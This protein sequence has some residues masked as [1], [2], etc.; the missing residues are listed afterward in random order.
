MNGETGKMGTT[1]HSS[2]GAAALSVIIPV[3]NAPAELDRCLQSVYVS[4]PPGTEVILIDDASPD[5]ATR[6]VLDR[7]RGKADSGW[8]FLVNSVNLGFV[9]T[10]NRGMRIASGDVVLLNSDTEVTR[11]WFEGLQRCLASDHL[12]ATATPWTNNGE[13]A[14]MPE[15][16]AANPVPPDREAVAAV[17]SA[18]GQAAYPELP[19]AVGFCMA[20]SRRAIDRI[21]FFDED[22]F[23]KGYG[24]EN[25]F[26]MRAAQAGMRN[27]LCDDVYVV[28]LGNR[29]FG[30]EGLQ[31]DEN[32]MNRLLSRHPGYLERVTEF[33]SA[34][35]LSARR[36]ALLDALGSAAVM[37]G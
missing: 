29:S 21:G 12:I 30:P 20:V 31:P 16:C 19:T 35:P 22:L 15:F 4:L 5:A 10:A 8:N 14:S 25:D 26:S 1:E 2:T 27:V 9:G 23:G 17:I 34:D 24:E 6:A 33:I 3:F 32:S 18:C 28:H 37:M 36:Q 13:I 11:G 7:W